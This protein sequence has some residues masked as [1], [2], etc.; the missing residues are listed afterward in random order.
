[1]ENTK[2]EIAGHVVE[3]NEI[4]T[5]GIGTAKLGRE[6]FVSR[7]DLYLLEGAIQILK[8]L[9]KKEKRVYLDIAVGKEQP[10]VIGRYNAE[11][12]AI[13]GIVIAPIREG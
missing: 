2:F 8:T 5:M 1:M 11:E 6:Y 4:R 3:D 12:R 10:I 13:A 7:V 9:H